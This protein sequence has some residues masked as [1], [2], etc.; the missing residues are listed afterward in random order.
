MANFKNFGF[1]AESVGGWVKGGGTWDGGAAPAPADYLP[2]GSSADIGWAEV[3]VTSAGTD[4]NT[5][6]R[7]STVYDGA[8]AAVVN[9]RVANYSV[10][11]LSQ[12]VTDYQGAKLSF[13]FAGL[14]EKSHDTGEADGFAIT[15]T[16]TTTGATVYQVAYD[17]GAVRGG[18]F[19]LSSAGWYYQAWQTVRIDTSALKGHDFTIDVIAY[20]CSLGGH[21]GYVYFDGFDPPAGKVAGTVFHDF[22]ANGAD[23][24]GEPALA[25]WTVYAD[26]NGDGMRN[27]GE[28]SALTD[29]RGRYLIDGVEAGEATIR[30]D[31]PTGTWEH[32]LAAPVTVTVVENAITRDVALAV[33]GGATPGDDTL[34]GTKA[35]ETIDGGAGADLIRSG[36]GADVVTGAAGD[37]TLRGYDGDDVLDGGTGCD[38]IAGGEGD[39][40]IDG[41]AGDDALVGRLGADLFVFGDAFGRDI[42]RDFSH[43]EG[44]RL[45]FAVAGVDDLSDLV[46]TQRGQNTVI[47]LAAGGTDTV[48]LHGVLASGLTAD[49]FVFGPAPSELVLA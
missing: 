45:Q 44:D 25:G 16:D 15:V 2:G 23:D 5:D 28:E 39:D 9:M 24:R 41:G 12:H 3:S 40:T 36:G 6:G 8:H 42:V 31:A 22:D 35:A 34:A 13:A 4:R 49:D 48:T 14:L 21:A 26:A 46:L 11:V 37:D 27:A 7:L 18:G 29:D 33:T 19:T 10:S 17:A 43:A 1:E 38:R 20:D 32:W 30:V 47:T